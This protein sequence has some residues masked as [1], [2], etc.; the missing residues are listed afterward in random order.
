MGVH[1][2]RC[3]VKSF[4]YLIFG[5]CF[6]IFNLDYDFSKLNIHVIIFIFEYRDHLVMLVSIIRFRCRMNLS[7]PL[8]KSRSERQ[9]V[10]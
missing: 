2:V 9:N 3:F 6:F 5:L 10:A 4:F 1:F 8:G 7:Y